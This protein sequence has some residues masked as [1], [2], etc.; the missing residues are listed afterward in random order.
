MWHGRLVHGLTTGSVVG[1]LLD[2]AGPDTHRR[3]AD[4]TGHMMYIHNPSLEKL[5]ADIGRFVG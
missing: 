2:R 3:A 4:A 1:S 5:K